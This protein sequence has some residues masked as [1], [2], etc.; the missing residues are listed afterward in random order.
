ME[1][2]PTPVEDCAPKVFGNVDRGQIGGA[3]SGD[4][5]HKLQIRH[6]GILDVE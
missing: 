2:R 3:E 1:K 4:K 5:E 6:A